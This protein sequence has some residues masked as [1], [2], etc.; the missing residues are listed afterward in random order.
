MSKCY[1][2]RS[3]RTP[4]FDLQKLD[5]EDQLGVARDSRK[6]LLA[7]SKMRRNGDT[8]LATRGHASNTD[9]PTLDD[10]TLAELEGERLA[11]LVCCNRR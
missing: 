7:V 3:T 1:D 9:I 4:L 8:A 10:F 2:N 11:L 5:V 6:A